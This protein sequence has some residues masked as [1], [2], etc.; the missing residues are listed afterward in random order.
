MLDLKFIRENIEAVKGACRDKNVSVDVERLVALDEE[1][2]SLRGRLDQLNQERR[3]TAKIKNIEQGKVLKRQAADLEEKLRTVE[4]ELNDLWL[5]IPN[6]PS[7]DTPIGHDETSN[8]VLRT[9]GEPTKFSFQ[10]QNHMALAARYGWIDN[11][12]AAAVAGS[13]FTYLKGDLVILQYALLQFGLSVL[14]SEKT[15]AKI[16]AAARLKTPPKPFLPV[17]PPLFIQP[18][19]FQKMARLEPKIERYHAERDELYLIGSAEHTLGP[20][21]MNETV[22]EDNL[23]LRFCAFT[24]AFRREAGSYGKDTHGILRLHQFDKL[25]MESF[26]AAEDGLLEQNFL[27]AIQEYLVSS[28][29]IPYRVVITCT[30][31]QGDPDARH[32][33][34]ECWM[35]GEGKYRE[36]HSADYMTDYQARR[37]AAKVVRKT[38]AEFLHMNDATVLAM[39]RMLIAI[40]ENGQQSDG[41]ILLPKVLNKYLESPIL[42]LT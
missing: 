4:N 1:R 13:R 31:D 14:T 12:K 7:D 29:E 22:K 11:E 9:V 30:G 18:E 40:L 23:P 25:E 10:P 38:G 2:R 5:L 33:D 35:P 19:V 6:L 24:P 32:L 39:G 15:L 17:V 27:V 36:T 26:T 21:L 28:L 41:T 37:L 42:P 16:A 20:L 3:Q 8:V 34:I